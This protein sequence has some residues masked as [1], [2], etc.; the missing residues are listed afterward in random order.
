MVNNK[1]VLIIIDG[2]TECM[3]AVAEHDVWPFRDS[4][5]WFIM[6]SDQ[7][8]Q[9]ISWADQTNISTHSLARCPTQ[10]HHITPPNSS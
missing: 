4:A 8:Q 3:S 10:F 2:A 9:D 6:R 7:Y 5:E 1:D